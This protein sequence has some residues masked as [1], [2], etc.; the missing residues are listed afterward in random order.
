MPRMAD[1]SAVA[2]HWARVEAWLQKKARR[3]HRSLAPGASDAQIAEL[4][5]KL[6]ITL[7]D[8]V[9]SSF[10]IHDGAEESDLFPSTEPDD[11]AYSLMSLAEIAEA[12]GSV[13]KW[14]HWRSDWVPLATNGGG[15]YQA[16]ALSSGEIVEANHETGAVKP[17]ACS[18]TARLAD[19]ANGLEA[20]RYKY[21][22]DSGIIRAP[23]PLDEL[24][25]AQTLVAEDATLPPLPHSP[26][27]PPN[28]YADAMKRVDPDGTRFGPA[29]FRR[30]QAIRW[31]R[32][33]SAYNFF[34]SHSEP[35]SVLDLHGLRFY[36]VPQ[37][38]AM[39]EPHYQP[40]VSK[41]WPVVFATV[42]DSGY[43]LILDTTQLVEYPPVT[44]IPCDIDLK[45]KTL[46]QLKP[47]GKQLAPTLLEFW[48][49]LADGKLDFS[50]P[51]K[52]K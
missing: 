35:T 40:D 3:I 52:S 17:V 43:R 12:Y 48:R 2:G 50:L 42:V 6:G 10:R 30:Q 38:I 13:C 51:T 20:K 14:P 41:E 47:K 39:N 37:V 26:L 1:D 49:R 44:L 19:L 21:D 29:A 32:G 5:R 22:A 34:F 27:G 31:F 9:R 15:D 45:G 36:P 4:E 8:D 33:S 28:E 16:V 7:P 24:R 25:K 11:M 23:D 18:W 46:K